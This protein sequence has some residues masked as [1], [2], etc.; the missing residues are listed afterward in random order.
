MPIDTDLFLRIMRN[1]TPAMG[2]G[3]AQLVELVPERGS[4]VEHALPARMV[5]D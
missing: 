2:P 1:E 5:V 4:A 3:K